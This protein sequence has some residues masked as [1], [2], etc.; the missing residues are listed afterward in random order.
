MKHKFRFSYDTTAKNDRHIFLTARFAMTYCVF[1]FVILLLTVYLH[2]VSTIRSEENFWYQNKSTF[3]NA[4]SL[5]DNHLST[6]ES[7][8]K[9]LT[10]NSQFYRLI[11]MKSTES[12][13]FYLSGLTMKHSIASYTSYAD[14]PINSCFVYLANTGYVISANTFNAQNLYYARNY[15]SNYSGYDDWSEMLHNDN[16]TGTMYSLDNYVLPNNDNK[17]LYL[18]DMNALTYKEINATLGFHISADKLENIF[19]GLSLEEGS[20]IITL[21]ESGVPVFFVGNNPEKYLQMYPAVSSLSYNNDYTNYHDESGDMHITKLPSRFNNWTF[22]L[23]QPVSLQPSNYQWL[24]YLVLF[25]AFLFGLSLIAILVRNN[26]RPIIQLNGQL[27]ETILDRN[28]LKEEVEA[29]KPIIYSNYLRQLLSGSISSTDELAFIQNYLNLSDPTLHYY[30]MY[31]IIYE[32]DF[33]ENTD[34]LQDALADDLNQKIKDLLAEYFSYQN[35]L[36]MYSPK[37]RVYAI[38]LP[39][40]EDSEQVLISVQEKVLK[41]H[42]QLLDEYSIW[43]FTGIGLPATFANIWESYQQAKDASGY[44]TKNYIFLP[45]EMLKKD[46]HVYYYPAEFSTKLIHSITSGNKTQVIEILDLIHQ[47]NIEERS[48]P[49]Q[50][51]RFLLSDM[52]NTLLKARF[53][54]TDNNDESSAAVAEIDEL[55]STDDF[56]FRLCRDIGMKLCDLFRKKTEKSNLVDT[57]VTFIHDNYKNPALCLSKISDEFHISES[58]FSHMF[59]ENMSV[60]FSV[61]LENLRLTEATRLITEGKLPLNDIAIEVGYNNQTSF[62]RAFKKKFGVTPSNYN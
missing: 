10:Q 29:V 30:V 33:V 28:Q 24:F 56:T 57:I 42:A 8:G 32:N 31:G 27:Q 21:D 54:Y 3:Q 15:L 39:F 25:V 11:E 26:M 2:H 62:R 47:E 6:M 17:Y 60:N 58:Y 23:I 19:S 13:D 37:K 51:L 14:L 46:S 61:Y 1:L 18:L 35:T 59:K 34:V 36:Y 41:F 7:V 52:R 12:N 55:L 44:T 40:K 20:G 48:L 16:G 49:F 4:I 9:Q 43:F 45:Y 5:F 22:Y 50:L 53:T 38:L